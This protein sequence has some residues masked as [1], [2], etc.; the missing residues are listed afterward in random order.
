M[1][2]VPTNRVPTHPGEML[3]E[4]FLVPMSLTRQQLANAVQLPLTLVN[5]I[6]NQERDVTP[7]IALRLEKGSEMGRH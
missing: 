4:E 7:R 5:D 6:I 3:L 1:I 2:R